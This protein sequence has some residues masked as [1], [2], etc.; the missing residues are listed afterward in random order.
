MLDTHLR[1]EKINGPSELRAFI[2][3]PASIYEN[4]PRWVPPL[5]V[6]EYQFH[7]PLKNP[8][9]KDAV[10]EKWIV[11]RKNL[12]VGRIM[13]IIHHAYNRIHK[14]KTARFFQMDCIDDPAVAS[15]LIKTVEAWAREHGMDKLIGPFGFSDKDPQGFQVQ[16][17]EHLPVIATPSNPA[18]MPALLASLG[19]EKYIDCVSYR[20][21]IPEQLPALYERILGRIGR[22]PKLQLLEFKSRKALKPYI[23]PVFQLINETYTPLFGFVPMS[24]AE[25]QKMAKQYLPILNPSFVKAMIDENGN[26]LSFVVAMPDLSMGLQKAK[27]KLFPFGLFHIFSA[28]RKSKQL[29]LLLGAVKEKYRGKGLDVYMAMALIQSASAR[30]MTH[31]DSHLILETNTTM[32][33]ECEKLGGELYKRFRIFQKQLI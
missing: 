5:Y 18:Y 4:I 33:A 13:G 31:M 10:T 3:L 28:M 11:Y 8:A 26:L 17:L 32:R 16:G 29:N 30:G 27:G 12:A 25:I 6:D 19:Y 9:Y 23:V 15:L 1:I 21:P 22:N 24:D 14:E 2:H 20:I 7:D